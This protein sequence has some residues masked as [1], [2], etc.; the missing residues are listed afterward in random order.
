[1]DLPVKIKHDK[2]AVGSSHCNGDGGGTEYGVSLDFVLILLSKARLVNFNSEVTVAYLRSGCFMPT[3]VCTA[4]ASYKKMPGSLELTESHLQWTQD[5]KK[6]P[7][8]RVPYSEAACQ[9]TIA[10][11]RTPR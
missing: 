9:Y 5:G 3:L 10:S 1:M 8:V 6:A 7:S 2:L 4:R 11:P